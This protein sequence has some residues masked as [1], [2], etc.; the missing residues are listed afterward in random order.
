MLHERASHKTSLP[1]TRPKSG[2]PARLSSFLTDRL[3]NQPL[4][5]ARV[6][7]EVSRLQH[8]GLTVYAL[9]SKSVPAR[10]G[11]STGRAYKPPPGPAFLSRAV[12]TNKVFISA[13]PNAGMVVLRAGTG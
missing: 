10:P 7:G 12:V 9:G 1:L 11:S 5:S 4:G 6:V 2:W 3:W 8:H 13:P